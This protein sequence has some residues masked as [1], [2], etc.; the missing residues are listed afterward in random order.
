MPKHQQEG[1]LDRGRNSGLGCLFV[2]FQISIAGHELNPNCIDG[3]QRG[4]AA[5]FIV[6][7]KNPTRLADVVEIVLIE[8]RALVHRQ[9]HHRR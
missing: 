4:D 9:T 2:V 1:L 5:P 6:R 8:C 7:R 3:I